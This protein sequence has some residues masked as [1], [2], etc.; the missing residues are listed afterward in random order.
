MLRRELITPAIAAISLGLVGRR[1][2]SS[3]IGRNHRFDAA[4]N[5]LIAGIMGML[6]SY[7]GK[8]TIFLAAAGLTVPGLIAL[9][10]VRKDEIDYNRARNASKDQ[11]GRPTLRSLTALLKNRQLL[12]FSCS[13]VFQLADASMLA[14]AVE[15]IGHN[16]LSQGSLITSGLIVAPQ[17]VVALLA[18]GSDISRSFGDVNGF[19]SSASRF[20]SC[21]PCSL[22][23]SAIRSFSLWSRRWTGSAAQS[24]RY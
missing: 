13:A 14:L 10:F 4:G 1:A 11:E 15:K 22:H 18:P 12:W 6:G 2:M 5:A 17:I 24:V 7:V 21:A 8:S 3:R 20:R 9:G 19:Y 16:D 23:S